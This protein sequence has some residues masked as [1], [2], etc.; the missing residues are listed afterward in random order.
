MSKAIHC[1]KCG[2]DSE[3]KSATD[4]YAQVVDRGNGTFELVAYGS[5]KCANCNRT[6]FSTTASAALDRDY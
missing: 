3:M 4:T 2:E 5:V 6:V 1:H